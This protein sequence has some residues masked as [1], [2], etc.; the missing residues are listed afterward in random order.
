MWVPGRW[1]GKPRTEGVGVRESGVWSRGEG[2]AG[3][4][5][6]GSGGGGSGAMT[7]GVTRVTVCKGGGLP[8]GTVPFMSGSS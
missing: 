1:R 2:S 6:S 3:G 8:A 5:G 7:V 4:G